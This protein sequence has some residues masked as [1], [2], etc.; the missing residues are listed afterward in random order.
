[1]QHELEALTGDNAFIRIPDLLTASLFLKLE[2]C[3]PAGSIEFKTAIRLIRGCEAAGIIKRDTILVESSSDNLG[4][5]LAMICAERGYRFKCIVEPRTDPHCTYAMRA[6]GAD[7]VCVSET[8]LDGD[9]RLAYIRD[10]LDGDARHVWVRQCGN[11]LRSDIHADLTAP[12]I[13]DR[14]RRVDYLF[15]DGGTTGMLAGCV[16][17]FSRWRPETRIIAVDVLGSIDGSAEPRRMSGN[18]SATVFVPEIAA[19]MSC[20]YLAR[21]YGIL[22]GQSTGAVITAVLS[23]RKNFHQGEVVVAIAPDAGEPYLATIYND[24]WVGAQF[25]VEALRPEMYTHLIDEC[26]TD[27]AEEFAQREIAAVA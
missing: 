7:V 9:P 14:F 10:L 8:T 20:R 12:A 13:A 11:G 23:W 2:F 3:N 19:A 17:Y 24:E 16:S 21:S 26:E 15:V 6:L 22:T 4:V 1:M 5:A 25:G 18:V 27:A